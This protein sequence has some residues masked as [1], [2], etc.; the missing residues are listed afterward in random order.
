MSRT[1]ELRQKFRAKM[2]GFDR[3]FSDFTVQ[4]DRY[5]KSRKNAS[6]VGTEFVKNMYSD[7]QK[8]KPD[9]V[10]KWIAEML[11]DKFSC[12]N[13]KP[14][15]P[16]E[17]DW[18]F[19]QSQ[20]MKFLRQFTDSAGTTFFLFEAFRNTELGPRALYKM[21]AQDRESKIHL[22]GKISG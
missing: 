1:E 11:Q 13:E 12:D 22:D 21:L 20:P 15:W 17:P 10:D 9:D 3:E 8:T 2:Q 19:F 5:L 6:A 7:Y 16:Y 4:V 18:C 14:N